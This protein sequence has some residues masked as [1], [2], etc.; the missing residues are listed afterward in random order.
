MSNDDKTKKEDLLKATAEAVKAVQETID[1]SKERLDV[2]ENDKIKKASDAAVKNLEKIQAIDLKIKA[3]EERQKDIEL[4]L[5][6]GFNKEDDGVSVEYRKSIDNYLRK[7]VAPSD[8]M[9]E[10]SCRAVVE[11][12]SFSGD[13]NVIDR[14]VKDMIS[15]SN[16]DG[17]YLVTPD[18]APGMQTRLFETSPIRSVA[19]IESSISDI[20]EILLDDDEASCGWVGEVETR[21]D[22][23]TAG[24]GLIKIPMHEI[25][26][27][28]RASQRTLN[29][30]GMDLE[31]YINKKSIDKI[32]RTENTAFVV[33]DGSKKPKGFLDYTNWSSSGVYER[34]AVE[35]RIGTDSTHGFST[36]DLI[37]LQNDLHEEY[38]ANAVFAMSR[39]TFAKIITKKGTDGQYLLDRNMLLNNAD[40]MLLGK[41]VIIMSDMPELATDSLSIVYG[42]FAEGYTIVDGLGFRILRDPYTAKPYVIFYTTKFV[43]GA[44]TNFEALKILKSNDVV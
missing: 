6:K 34:N 23:L 5:A 9:I 38:Q 32:S 40:K 18:R 31:G 39:T 29:N 19:N 37:L 8:E 28:P 1:A 36:D 12:K 42:N 10:K 11:S 3:Y 35:Q 21:A 24:I 7:G 14:E 20:F 15:A 44:V 17:G 30:A 27:K 22:T 26:A 33:G 13:S 2:L 43:G 25:Y 4:S 41:K 16:A